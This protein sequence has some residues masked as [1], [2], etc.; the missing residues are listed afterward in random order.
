MSAGLLLARLLAHGHRGIPY[1]LDSDRRSGS[2]Y[3]VMYG[4]GGVHV[5]L[6]IGARGGVRDHPRADEALPA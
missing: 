6:L 2:M 1:S 4:R 3:G 5:S